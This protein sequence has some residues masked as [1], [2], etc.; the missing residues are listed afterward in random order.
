MLEIFRAASEKGVVIVN[1]TQCW[2]GTVA[3]HYATGV[4]LR[5]V[6]LT[7]SL[8][9]TPCSS[10]PPPQSDFLSKISHQPN[11]PSFGLC[12]H[13]VGVVAAYDM[14]V[15]AALTKLGYLLGKDLSPEAVRKAFQT[16]L[17]GEMTVSCLSAL[18][19]NDLGQHL[20]LPVLGQHL[21]HPHP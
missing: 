17:R 18:I 14:T 11:N 9:P 6:R 20:W 12:G 3:A 2:K 21:T 7:L 8:D 15:E 13:Q 5:E 1:V 10:A 19:I 16:D 4:A